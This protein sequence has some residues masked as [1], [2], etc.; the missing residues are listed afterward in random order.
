MEN[1][2]LIALLRERGFDIAS[3]SST[4]ANIYADDLIN[5]FSQKTKAPEKE[6][7]E[8]DEAD[9]PEPE[10]KPKAKP[11]LP[12]GRFVKTAQEVEDEKKPE[13]EAPKPAPTPPA[14]IVKP[15]PTVKEAPK[16]PPIVKE[17]P[18][19]PPIVKEAPKT[20][21]IVKEAPKTP[22]IVKEAPKA[23]QT[24]PP[25]K[26]PGAAPM[27]P[28][29]PKAAG[30]PPSTPPTPGTPTADKPAEPEGEPGSKTI[31]LKPP[32][33][34]RDFAEAIGLRPFQLISVLMEKGIFASIDRT[35]EAEV[36]QRI[37]KEH[38]YEL[39]IRHRGETQ[40]Q[41]KGKGAP[42]EEVVENLEPRPPV[43][44]I[45]G[46]VDHGK[47]TLI[48]A[49]RKANVVAGEAGGIT[50]HVAAYQVEHND[51]KIS[52]IDT[53][54]H[55][56]F[57]KIR[58]RGANVTDIAILVVA[59]DDGFKPQ[60]D[61]ALKFAQ[62][63][64]VPIVVAINKTDAKGANIDK[65]KQEMQ[66]RN[67]APEDWGGETLC[68][69]ISALKG[70]GLEDLLENVLL[71]AEILELKAN[72]ACP[73]EGIIVESRIDVG[74]GST[75]TV[76][77]QKGTLKVGDA[78][79][80]GETYCRVRALLDEAGNKLQKA[81]PAMPVQV[82]GWSDAPHAGLPFRAVKNEKKAKAEAAEAAHINKTEAARVDTQPELTGV[83]ALFQAI[84][85]QQ[86]KTLRCIIKGDV[87]GSVEAL[88]TA[89]EDIESAKVDLKVLDAEVGLVN[90]NDIIMANTSDAVVVAFNV[91]LDSGVPALAK[92][93]S[94]H[95]IS[96]Q[97]IYELID[98]VK[99]AMADLLDPEL[100]ENKIGGAEV[101]QV[102]PVSK[103]VVAG[104]MVT[105]GRITR[106]GHARVLRGGELLHQGRIDTLKRF[107]DDVADV[108]A[109]YECGIKVTGFSQY[110]E[111]DIIECLEVQKIQP[112]L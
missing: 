46:H 20:P 47:T 30:A 44:C 97:I 5:E 6:A 111:G 29:T 89:L 13:K 74:R 40:D 91:K 24:P 79:V 102:F 81:T 71:Q 103:G 86:K 37:A 85:S 90:K 68:V 43:V 69:P 22:P 96:H 95:I 34:V 104:C 75:A 100:R 32:I 48:D 77:I 109:G 101:R 110:E 56:A 76:I 17:A 35:I 62:K 82:L 42:K 112:K 57:A 78:L 88:R 80:C 49:I 61:E 65:V 98:Q 50:Q 66:Q 4:I 72:Y 105:D 1:K 106:D 51:H 26:S 8:A 41:P 99:E 14:N 45:L 39:E 83:D 52:F 108:R 28:A 84:E 63:A 73:A 67:I 92:Q 107:K 15:A 59:A 64:G 27:P 18:K 70:E 16:T 87:H 9:E 2:E 7:P 10:K 54:G 55:A 93:H 3:A 33:V 23:P 31:S 60:T 12:T 19:T 21:P 53:P 36:A 94:I 58:E 11:E 25:A 38:G